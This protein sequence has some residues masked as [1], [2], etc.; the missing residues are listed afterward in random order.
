MTGR[1]L[2]AALIERYSPTPARRVPR[3]LHGPAH[4]RVAADLSL[5]EMDRTGS[6]L[7]VFLRERPDGEA[8]LF[9]GHQRHGGA[10]FISRAEKNQ[11]H[12]FPVRQ[13]VFRD[14]GQM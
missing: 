8:L 3:A 2:S 10:N 1:D 11:F 13:R 12:D 9:F 6:W 14:P 5:L 7:V 4:A